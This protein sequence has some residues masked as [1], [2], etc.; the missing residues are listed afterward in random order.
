MQTIRAKKNQK[1]YQDEGLLNCVVQLSQG[2][3][4]I[5]HAIDLKTQL[6][7]SKLEDGSEFP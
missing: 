7:A 5:K 4:Q 3:S 2:G 1:A 6:N